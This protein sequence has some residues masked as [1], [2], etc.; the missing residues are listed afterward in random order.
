M[1]S[2]VAHADALYKLQALY[3]DD[4]LTFEEFTTEKRKLLRADAPPAAAP[5]PPVAQGN[6]PVVAAIQQLSSAMQR[7]FDRDH[8]SNG[9]VATIPSFGTEQPD[10]EEYIEAGQRSLYSVGVRKFKQPKAK[11]T[12]ASGK[13]K[14]PH[15]SKICSK[16]NA[17]AVHIKAKHGDVTSQQA[18]DRGI[19]GCFSNQ[20]V[21]LST[22][23]QQR[24]RDVTIRFIINDI[25]SAA[26]KQGSSN[27]KKQKKQSFLSKARPDGRRRNA[28]AIRRQ[29]RS[30]Q[31]KAKIILEHERLAKQHPDIACHASSI[32]S[33]MYGI[34]QQQVNDWRRNKTFI[35]SEANSNRRRKL[36]KAGK[37]QGLFPKAEEAVMAQF[38]VSR[39]KGRQVGP[40]W[41]KQAMKREVAKL[42]TDDQVSVKTRTAARVFSAGYGW[43][44][45]FCKRNKICLR[46]KTNVKKVP[47]HLRL[48]KLKRWFAIFRCYLLSFKA[49]PGYDEAFSIFPSEHRWSLD[50]VP[51]GLYDPKSS[52]EF[53][54]AQRVHVAC[55]GSADSHRFATLQVLV[56]NATDDR[57]PRC[58]QP[59]LC[60][61]FRGTGQ[62]ISDAEKAQYHKDVVVMWQP[63]AWFDS[64]TCN[65]WVVGY[66]ID[67]IKKVDLQPGQRHLILCDNLGGQTKKTNPSFAKLLDQ[68][69]N[70]EVWNLLAQCTDEIQVVDAGFGA[71]IKRHTEEV[72]MEWLQIE[73]NWAEWTGSDMSASRRRILSTLWYG[74]GYERACMAFDFVKVFNRTGGNLTADGS[75]DSDIKLQGMDAPLEFSEEDAT[76]DPLTGEINE[77]AEMVGSNAAVVNNDVACDSEGDEIEELSENEG[78]ASEG[79]DT[80]DGEDGPPF[81]DSDYEILEQPSNDVLSG[82]TLAHR[83]DEGGYWYV[84]EIRRKVSLSTNAHENGRWACKYPDSRKEFFHDLF[85]EDYGANKVWVVVKRKP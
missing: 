79:G 46:R 30:Y 76:R 31:F 32:V 39:E 36:Q 51:A 44:S 3:T 69:C 52:Y 75:G 45:R 24:A 81:A 57:L 11:L 12:I 10:Q 23:Q 60:M 84:G 17:L 34:S 67:E 72:Q 2:A 5:T 68:H 43:L 33:D 29:R 54:G 66:A 85:P 58:G 14:C 7:F 20:G 42:T 78:S 41:I 15:C 4:V 25:V 40:K 1:S 16:A 59:R 74:E 48:G 18:S 77:E 73:E 22:S 62:R 80:T 19:L 63:K 9:S 70:A 82:K 8:S 47:I 55:N 53:K 56:R 65:K 27:C 26:E 71:L 13:L 64:A 61:C 50:Q 38:K 35:L 6:D 49:K 21:V 28:G 83:F 37:K